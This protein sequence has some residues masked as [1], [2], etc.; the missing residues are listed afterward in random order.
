MI[1]H[2]AHQKWLYLAQNQSYSSLINW[3]LKK[4]E[5]LDRMFGRWCGGLDGHD[6]NCSREPDHDKDHN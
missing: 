3:V 2:S 5:C 6:R 4:E 1:H